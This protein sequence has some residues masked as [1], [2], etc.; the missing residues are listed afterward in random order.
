MLF[1]GIHTQVLLHK[2]LLQDHHR[3][4]HATMTNSSQWCLTSLHSHT[5][6]KEKKRNI[7][8]VFTKTAMSILWTELG[9]GSSACDHTI[10]D[11]IIR[12]T[13]KGN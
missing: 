2:C 11:C 10:K 3:K 12:H 1:R 4:T 8:E 5:L 9:T 7:E 13:H 6:N